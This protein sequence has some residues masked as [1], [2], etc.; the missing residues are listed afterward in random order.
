MSEPQYKYILLVDGSVEDVFENQAS[1]EGAFQSWKEDAEQEDC[2]ESI[3]L[4][5]AEKID[6]WTKEE[7][8]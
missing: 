2:Y 8:E 4:F 3:E 7:N 6:Y 5:K 1:A